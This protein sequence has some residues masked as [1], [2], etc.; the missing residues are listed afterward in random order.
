MTIKYFLSLILHGILILI[1]ISIFFV[2]NKTLTSPLYAGLWLSSSM[3]L[4]IA[5]FALINHCIIN[6]YEDSMI[7]KILKTNISFKS[8]KAN[9]P[10]IDNN[11]KNDIESEFGI[12]IK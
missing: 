12:N 1:S 4:S 5:L 2:S 10:I 11:T 3:Y 7:D 8:K 9:I 6:K